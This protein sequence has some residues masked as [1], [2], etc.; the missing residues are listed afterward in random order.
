MTNQQSK[1]EECRNAVERT[2]GQSKNI[3]C[4]VGFGSTNDVADSLVDSYSIVLQS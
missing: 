3:I 2:V 4:W 1:G